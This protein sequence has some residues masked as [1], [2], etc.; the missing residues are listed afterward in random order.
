MSSAQSSGPAGSEGSP[1]GSET[2]G[3]RP[4]D[5][6]A[7][8]SPTMSK[9]SE[10][11]QSAA[12][13]A[14]EAAAS[15]ASEANQKVRGAMNQQVSA[16][17]DLVGQVAQSIRTA[18]DELGRN[19]PQLAGFVRGA[20]DRVDEFSDALREQS[21]EQLLES[22]SDFARRRPLV[23][24]SA[25]AAC[26]FAL[27][28]VLKAAPGNGHRAADQGFGRQWSGQMERAQHT[29][30]FSGASPGPQGSFGQAG[31]PVHRPS[32][33]TA[34]GPGPGSPGGS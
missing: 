26:G 30:P 14:R 33:T 31:S 15:L 27:F 34:V 3:S 29:P 12:T 13:Q 20:A 28:R 4:R 9:L 10:T 25:A 32:S 19:I 8:A 21:V 17:A 6:G 7:T 5:V 1:L 24:F 2:A 18:A 22:A 16:G 23:V 11:A